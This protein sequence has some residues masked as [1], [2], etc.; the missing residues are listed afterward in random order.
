[1]KDRLSCTIK[2]HSLILLILPCNVQLLH[3]DKMV[4]CSVLVIYRLGGY[5]LGQSPAICQHLYVNCRVIPETVER[6]R[7]SSKPKV[8]IY[9]HCIHVIDTFVC[10]THSW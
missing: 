5:F 2:K 10:S 9:V 8:G 6:Q 7:C 4:E 3:R 1:M